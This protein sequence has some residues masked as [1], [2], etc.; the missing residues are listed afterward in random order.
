MSTTPETLKN[1]A[2][3]LPDISLPEYGSGKARRIRGSGRGAPVLVLLHD[4]D[5]AAC[6]E[7]VSRL[8][9][10]RE[11]IAD[12][13]GEMMVVLPPSSADGDRDPPEPPAHAYTVLEDEQGRIAASLG[14]ATPAVVIADRW[15]EIRMAEPAGVEHDFYDP[16]EVVA[17][18]R[19]IAIECPECQGE[20]Y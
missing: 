10:K 5:C 2:R 17:W 15:G 3:R 11:E 7:Y 1:P 4:A 20:A 19:F 14:I 6:W 16:G 12:W 18:L 13:D 9:A 8:T